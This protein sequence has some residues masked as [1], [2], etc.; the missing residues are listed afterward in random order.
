MVERLIAKQILEDGS[1]GKY[2]EPQKQRSSK[3]TIT[4]KEGDDS[5]KTQVNPFTI[6]HQVTMHL[7]E[8]PITLRWQQTG[9]VVELKNR[10]QCNKLKE[11]KAIKGQECEISDH[12]Q[13]NARAI[14]N[15]YQNDISKTANFKNALQKEYQIIDVIAANWIQTKTQRHKIFWRLSVRKT[16]LNTYPSPENKQKLNSLN[17]YPI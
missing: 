11:I 1:Q 6:S 9:Y 2:K 16:P 7:G 8:K 15:T 17:T 12:N 14:F 4:I 5:N 3:M 13:F 10:E